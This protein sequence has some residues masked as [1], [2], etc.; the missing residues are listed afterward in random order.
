M[1][2]SQDALITEF[3]AE[4]DKSS[5][6]DQKILPWEAY[7]LHLKLDAAA[8]LG[9]IMLCLREHSVNVVKVIAMTGHPETMKARVRA[10]KT[11]GGVRDRDALD[12]GLGFLPVPKGGVT[13]VNRIP[14]AEGQEELEEGE[15]EA[16]VD[17][18]FPSLAETQKKLGAARKAE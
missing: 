17:Y 7:C 11:M 15:T 6:I 4:Y 14:G 18:L 5:H 16:D 9:A 12:R 2:F 10:A 8:L 3:L 1:R 13:I